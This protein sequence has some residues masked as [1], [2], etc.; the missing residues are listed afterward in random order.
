MVLYTDML[1]I[2]THEII[3]C[4]MPTFADYRGNT[5]QSLFQLLQHRMNIHSLKQVYMEII[6]ASHDT[7]SLHCDLIQ[8]ASCRDDNLGKHVHVGSALQL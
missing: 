6:T 4:S 5:L 8:K 3:F 2:K 1:Y 7:L